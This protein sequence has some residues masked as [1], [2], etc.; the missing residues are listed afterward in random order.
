MSQCCCWLVYL[1]KYTWEVGKS[2]RGISKAVDRGISKA[3]GGKMQRQ[4]KQ[5]Q[6]RMWQKKE[7]QKQWKQKKLSSRIKLKEPRIII[8]APKIHDSNLATQRGLLLRH[9]SNTL[10]YS[11]YLIN[12]KYELF[13]I[14]ER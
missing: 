10:N 3:G 1:L 6:N 5:K 9:G 14:Q 13:L 12:S 8:I 11:S 4:V 7:E 2:G